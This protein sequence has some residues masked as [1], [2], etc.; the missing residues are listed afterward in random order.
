MRNL[1]LLLVLGISM[2]AAAQ[3]SSSA[4]DVIL[5]RGHIFTADPANPWAQAVAIKGQRIVAVGASDTIERLADKHTNVIA[6]RG[7]V[8]IPGLNDAHYHQSPMPQ[9]FALQI[10]P[11]TAKWP[12]VEAALAGAIDETP[13]SIWIVGTIGPRVLLDPAVTRATLDKAAPG[14]KVLLREFTG[15]G[16]ICS[17]AA[18]KALK[19]GD[20]QQD[21]VGGRFERDANNVIDGK[22][23]EYADYGFVS[24]PLAESVSDEEAVDQLRAEADL[25][26]HYGITSMQNMSLLT[27]PRYERIARAANVPLRIR[28]I[29]WPFTTPSARLTD[30]AT[31]KKNDPARPLVTVSGTK[32]I[33]DGTPVERGAALRNPYEANGGSGTLN[34]TEP[35]LVKMLKESV[36]ANDQILLHAVGD[37]AANEVFTAM[38]ESGIDWSAR[39]LRIEHGDGLLPDL[40][41]TAHDLGVV[42]VINPTHLAARGLYPPGDYMP[43]QTLLKNGIPLA[44]GSDGDL[45]PF[46]N[47]ML[48]VDQRHENLTREEAVIAYTRGS[49]YAEFAEKE[50]GSIEVGK[51]ADLAVLSQDIFGV[52]LDQLPATKSVLTMV[53][54]E[55]VFNDIESDARR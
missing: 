48:A 1:L 54:G 6:L 3:E 51:L 43:M 19:I 8:V 13:A 21:P 10:D 5:L 53:N 49:A 36:A 17:S 37:A 34:F 33:L 44:I 16:V 22:V 11:M 40:I 9:H 52:H 29:H 2:S 45:N 15:H 14:R 12:Q 31:L 38:K 25:A 30:G 20:D 26:L 46:L 42:V 39:R 18:L 32:W 35:E 28:I 7:R 50:K 24:R 27:A 41:P 47:I 23:F 55:I 4:P